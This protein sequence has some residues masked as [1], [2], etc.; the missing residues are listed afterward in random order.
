MRS[1]RLVELRVGFDRL[2]QLFNIAAQ[3]DVGST[4]RHVGRDSDHVRASRLRDDVR[5]ARVLLGVEDL[6]RQLLLLEQLRDDFGVFNRGGA[7]QYRLATVIAF[8]Y[9]LD[10]RLV[11]L[12]RRLVDPVELVLA[13]AWPVVRHDDGF[14]AVDFLK[15]VGLGVSG[16][17]HACELAVKTKVVLEGDRRQRLVLGLDR[18]ALLGFDRLV[19]AVAPAPA[20][21]QPPGELV[22][23]DDLAGLH[24]IVLV[25]V[26]QVAGAQR[27]VQ[28]VHQ[29]DV[30]R[31]VER[32]TLWNQPHV[33]QNALGALVAL[34]GQHHLVALFVEREVAR[35]GDALAGARVGLALLATELGHHLVDREVQVGLV[36]G[37]AADDQ[38][39]SRLVDQNRVDLVDDGI[40]QPALHPV[41]HL[42]DHVVAQ[43]VETVFV[44]GAVGD[45][46]AVSGLLVFARH[47]RQVDADGQP[48]EVVKLAHPLRV[49]VGQIVI[50]RDD[51]DTLAGKRVQVDRQRRRQ[52]LAL[53]GPHFRNF[54]VMQRHA[55]EQLHVEVAHPHDALGAFAH[56]G[57]GVCQQIVER[58]ASGDPVPEGLRLGAQRIVAQPLQVHFHRVHALHR[59][60]VLFEQAVIATAENFGQEV[61]RHACKRVRPPQRVDRTAQSSSKTGGL[62]RTHPGTRPWPRSHRGRENRIENFTFVPAAAFRPRQRR[63]RGPRA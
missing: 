55:A 21:H 56:H 44:V 9:V 41:G 30:G 31:V 7:N 38:R 3:Y 15:L 17:G 2:Q 10:R 6:V 59:D 61:G 29:R 34:L 28:V 1:R 23:D 50:D 11:F 18:D 5:L 4:P 16:A 19:Q 40:V 46:G 37:L 35:L 62:R 47:L 39:R 20:R 43:V 27:S 60:P 25:A 51:M 33:V 49:A 14:Q 42:V 12:A 58:F 48:Q 36:L 8:A 26:V 24:H 53:A 45:V 32:R 52:R 13:P 57:E 63:L 54:S 22:D